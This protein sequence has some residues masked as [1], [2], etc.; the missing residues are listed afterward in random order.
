MFQAEGAVRAKALWQEGAEYIQVRCVK[1]AVSEG[2][3]VQAEVGAEPGQ[4]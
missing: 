3:V 1:S 4:P 2:E